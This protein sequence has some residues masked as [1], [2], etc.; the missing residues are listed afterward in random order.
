MSKR[1]NPMKIKAVFTYT[2]AEAAKA[3]GNS[4]ATIRKW[5]KD[6]LPVMG[7]RK[8][9]LISGLA[10]RTYIREKNKAAKRPLATDELT[11][12]SCRAGRKPAGM[13]V[14]M[15]PLTTKTALLKG[16]CDC[17]EAKATRIIATRDIPKFA[18]TFHL[19]KSAQSAAY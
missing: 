18:E 6:G 7:S 19:T 4:Q 14:N 3:L 15:V 17:C 1:A 13:Y 9:M 2:P 5:V 10:L 16:K 12:L 8:P 11:C